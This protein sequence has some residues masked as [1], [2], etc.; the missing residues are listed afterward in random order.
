ME[1]QPPDND[2]DTII[3][4][5]VSL[6]LLICIICSL[7]CAVAG[8]RADRRK[9]KHKQAQAEDSNDS[10]PGRAENIVVGQPLCPTCGQ[11]L[12]PTGKCGKDF[13]VVA[14]KSSRVRQIV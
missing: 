5:S 2:S 3:V 14:N 7:C 8:W 6:G 1:I 12:P 10:K 4:A 11:A 13:D 9:K